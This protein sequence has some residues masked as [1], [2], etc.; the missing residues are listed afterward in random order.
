MNGSIEQKKKTF[1][2]RSIGFVT[3]FPTVSLCSRPNERL[4]LPFHVDGVVCDKPMGGF[5]HTFHVF[6]LALCH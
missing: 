6:V 1:S 5:Y 2:S 4:R 3:L